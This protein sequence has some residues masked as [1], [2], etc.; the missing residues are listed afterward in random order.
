M[1]S[2]LKQLKQKEQKLETELEKQ[3]SA[4]EKTLKLKQGAE[5]SKLEEAAYKGRLKL[6]QQ[7][8]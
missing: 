5:I 8:F 1:E 3:K 6:D 7:T 2:E 4:I